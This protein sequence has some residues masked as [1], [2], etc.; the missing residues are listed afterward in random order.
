M[1]NE[2]AKPGVIK[3]ALNKGNGFM[4]KAYHLAL[5]NDDG[6]LSITKCVLSAAVVAYLAVFNPWMLVLIFELLLLFCLCWF[7]FKLFIGKDNTE[8][9]P[10][11]A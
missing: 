5:C 6:T 11:K 9:Q 2:N 4:K 1:A 8:Q 3:T 10:V 7:V